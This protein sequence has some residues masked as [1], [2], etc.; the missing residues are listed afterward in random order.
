[1]TS[2]SLTR[3]DPSEFAR[4][5]AVIAALDDAARAASGHEA[6]GD[7]VW[8]DLERPHADS[9]GFL[10]E[11][12]AYAHVARSDAGEHQPAWS[13][14]LVE[15][16]GRASGTSTGALLDALERHV[17]AHGGGHLTCW[18]AGASAADD[19]HFAEAGWQLTRELYEMRVG[20][21]LPAPIRLPEG[22]TVRAFDP[23]RDEETWLIANNR[24]FA[25]HPE[26]GSW[27]IET[28]RARESESWFDPSLFLLAFDAE[29]LAGFNWLKLHEPRGPDPMLGEIYVI[30]VDPRAQGTGLGRVLAVE[31]LDVVYRRGAPTGMLFC[32]A[33]NLGALSLYRSLGFSVHRTDHA[34]ELEVE[35]A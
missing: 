28:L 21:P 17:A 32:A 35:P 31:G 30:G 18:L 14:G 33:D 12:R 4:H 16:P 3:I 25:H 13:A 22:L 19:T 1:M 8:R 23:A 5:R 15:V 11:E 29:G 6:L 27:G 26:Q 9:A 2:T 34:Y 10:D 7:A 24:A 20:L